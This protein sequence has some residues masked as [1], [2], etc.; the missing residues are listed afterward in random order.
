MPKVST[1]VQRRIA[2]LGAA[3]STVAQPK[4][5]GG[6]I[7]LKGVLALIILATFAVAA[8][9]IANRTSSDFSRLTLKQGPTTPKR[10]LSDAEAQAKWNAVWRA[11]ST[12]FKSGE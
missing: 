8:F 9:S 10:L 5:P 3:Q 4:R 1:Q 7:A 11:A 2:E 6:V 12:G